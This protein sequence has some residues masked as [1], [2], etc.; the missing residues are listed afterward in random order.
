MKIPASPPP[1]P[2]KPLPPPSMRRSINISMDNEDIFLKN[3]L[4]NFTFWKQKI[5]EL[6]Q[7]GKDASKEKEYAQAFR[8]Q[9]NAF[10]IE[11]EI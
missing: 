2:I 6:E 7:A 8:I 11:K 4:E 10:T 5:A 3:A 1:K 9:L